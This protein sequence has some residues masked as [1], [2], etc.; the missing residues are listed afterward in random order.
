MPGLDQFDLIARNAGVIAAVLFVLLAG[1]CVVA[2]RAIRAAKA[3]FEARIAEQKEYTEKLLEMNT[4][5][6]KTGGDITH[7][8]SL[9]LERV[10]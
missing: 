6:T 8:L 2:W 3:S 10:K 7:Q 9:L 1:A 5:M 4:R